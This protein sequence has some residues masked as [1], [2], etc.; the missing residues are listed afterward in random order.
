MAAQALLIERV[1]HG[2]AGAVGRR[3]G[4]LGDA[5]AVVRGHA[6]EGALIDLAVLGAAER[7]AVVLE[8]EDRRHGL[9]HHVR[10]E[11]HTSELQSLMRN[12]YSVICLIK[13]TLNNKTSV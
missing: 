3:A 13:K 1:Q 9:A 5:F 6:A 11:E 8:L 10:S 2:V 7:H 12:S 4:A